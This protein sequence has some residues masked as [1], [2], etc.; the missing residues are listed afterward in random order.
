MISERHVMTTFAPEK[1][2]DEITRIS[3]NGSPSEK[4]IAKFLMRNSTELTGETAAT[5]A[6]K[7]KLSPMTVGR[8]L[9]SLGFH[10]LSELVSV[11]GMSGNGDLSNALQQPAW[12]KEE[13]GNPALEVYFRQ[14]KAIQATLR[15]TTEPSWNETI[16]TIKNAREIFVTSGEQ[17]FGSALHFYTH[18]AEQLEGVSYMYASRAHLQLADTVPYES[19][20]II[21]DANDASE[22]LQR[23]ARLADAARVR[24]FV[25]TTNPVY[26]TNSEYTNIITADKDSQETAF[27]SVQL[28]SLMELMVNAIKTGEPGARHRDAKIAKLREGLN[29]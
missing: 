15:L 18:L 3:R 2:N 19:I 4:R 22:L 16:E 20:L 21:V 28:S 17:I 6:D 14:V 23:L 25:L 24:T 8:F 29:G 27:D 10:E 13:E 5:L 11:L 7:L 1:L 12:I 26:W 9:R